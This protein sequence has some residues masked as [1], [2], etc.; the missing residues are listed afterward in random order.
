MYLN[1]LSYKDYIEAYRR[2]TLTLDVFKYFWVHFLDV[3]VLG[4]TLTLDVFK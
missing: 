3:D 4:L 2:L 1:N